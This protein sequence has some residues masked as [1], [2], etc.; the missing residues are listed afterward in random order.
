MCL[1]IIS[2]NSFFMAIGYLQGLQRLKQ[3]T[4]QTR[5][6]EIAPFVEDRTVYFLQV[7]AIHEICDYSQTPVQVCLFNGS[8]LLHVSSS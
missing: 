4:L 7:A 8:Q 3:N 5:D 2:S 6:R 1:L